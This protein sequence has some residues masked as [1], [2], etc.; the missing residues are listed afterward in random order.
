MPLCFEQRISGQENED[1]DSGVSGAHAAAAKRDSTVQTMTAHRK[2]GID[3]DARLAEPNLRLRVGRH[4]VDVGALKVANS[5]DAPRLSSKAMAVLIELVRHAGDTVTRDR[6]LDVVWK[7]RVTTPDVLTQAIK[8]LRRALDDEGAPTCIETIPKV[9]YRLVAPVQWMDA[10]KPAP[11]TAEPAVPSNAVGLR[12]GALPAASPGHARSWRLPFALAGAALLVAFFAM[13]AW[14]ARG[15]AKSQGTGLWHASQVHALTSDPGAERRPHVSPDGSRIAFGIT[16]P[17][18]SIGRIVVRTLEQSKLVRLTAEGAGYEWVPV[19]SPDGTRIAYQTMTNASDCML[20]VAVSLGGSVRDIGRCRVYSSTYYDWTPDGRGLLTADHEA[21]DKPNLKLFV[22]DLDSGA[23]RYLDYARDPQDQD[24]EGRYS[25]DGRRIAFRRG[26]APYSDLFMMEADGSSVHA[27]THLASRI[28]GFA[29][30][31]D[32]SALVFASDHAGP[33]A[34]YVVD[35]ASGDVHALGVSPAE[36]PDAA[37]TTDTVVYEIP[38]A[39]STLSRASLSGDAPS[40]PQPLARSTGSDFDPQ[41]SPAGDRVAFVSDRSGQSQVWLQDLASG[42]AVAL[43]GAVDI[44]TVSP[45]WSRDGKS[46]VMIENAAGKRR[47]VEMDIASRQRRVLSHADENVLEVAAGAAGDVYVWAADVP[48]ED[49]R[50][51]RVRHA[52]SKDEQRDVIA[53]AVSNV[54][55][56]SSD[57]TLYFSPRTVGGGV[58]RVAFDHGVATQVPHEVPMRQGRWRVF[59]GELWYFSDLTEKVATLNAFDLTAG[60]DRKVAT[61]HAIVLDTAFSVLP[62]RQGILIAPSDRDDTDVG[63]LKLERRA[64][65]D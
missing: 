24:L 49:D 12:P 4:V 29:W 35:T 43:T 41:L 58:Y 47:L 48:G 31:R 54:D 44:A 21:D 5:V 36:W 18:T 34:L 6:F 38:R 52:G 63:M 42:D 30:T 26:I 10:D 32:G 56:D 27:L 62:D 46:L 53:R 45:R 14:H 1:D 65:A 11:L 8:E 20:H 37:R 15:T 19:W 40:T 60:R 2:E 25:P 64:Y 55:F 16:E 3:I 7:D 59:G 22:L 17:G 9:G 61:L 13:L 39:H 51:V 33:M 50:L 28:H 57:A 23:K